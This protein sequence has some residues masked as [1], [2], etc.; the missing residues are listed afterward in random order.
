MET[1]LSAKRMEKVRLKCGF[2][3]GIDVG[4]IGSS[5]DLSLGWKGNS[6]VNLKSFSSFHIDAEIHDN[7]SGEVWR[8]TGFYGHPDGR[9]R[10][11]S[12]NLLKCLS[13][14]QSR[15]WVV[16]GD[17]NEIANSFEKKGG[18]RRSKRKMSEFRTALD[19]C[20]LSDLG[21]VGR[22][23]TWERGKF[24]SSIIRERLD[25]GVATFDWVNLFP[26][27]QLEHLSHSFSDH[28]PILLDTISKAQ[29]G[30]HTQMRPFRF[31][32]KCCLDSSLE[33]LIKSWWSEECGNVEVKIENLGRR[34]QQ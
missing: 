23:Y 31:E 20:Q 28:C 7:E 27:Y 5:G 2:E 13:S 21:F 30:Y 16:L 33:N 24:L 4:A 25:R 8:L 29:N 18:R 3:N 26:N 14:D 9:K 11:D 17:F 6:L 32:A 15:P 22:W 1:K 12:W 34:L 10:N 19:E